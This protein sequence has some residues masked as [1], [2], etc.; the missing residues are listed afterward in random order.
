MVDA[1]DFGFEFEFLGRL[2]RTGAATVFT[3][4]TAQLGQGLFICVDIFYVDLFDI[5]GLNKKLSL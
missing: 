1:V 4:N 2:G 3:Q 5:G